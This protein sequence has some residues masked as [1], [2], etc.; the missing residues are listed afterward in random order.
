MVSRSTLK[1]TPTCSNRTK[2]LLNQPSW[3]VLSQ[4]S[5]SCLGTRFGREL[6]VSA[7]LLFDPTSIVRNTSVDLRKISIG[8]IARAL[9]QDS[10]LHRAIAL[11]HLHIVQGGSPSTH[12]ARLGPGAELFVL[13]QP[14]GI[15]P[16]V[17]GQSAVGIRTKA[18][19]ERCGHADGQFRFQNGSLGNVVM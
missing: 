9:R 13:F 5:A 14:T 15:V 1:P 10:N 3:M 4:T 12:I 17:H 2:F 18:K 7:D 19:L 16:P 6:R 11:L 8:T